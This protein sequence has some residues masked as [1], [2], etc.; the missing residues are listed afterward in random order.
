IEHGVVMSK[1]P[2]ITVRDLPGTIR[3]LPGV[4][5]PGGIT[6]AKAYREKASPLDLH[7]SENRLIM[8]ALATTEGNITAAAKKLGISRRT[9]TRKIN[10]MKARKSDADSPHEESGVNASENAG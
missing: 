2:K 9:L 10:E 7:E 4:V 3:Q 1:G 8:Q 5:L 6:P